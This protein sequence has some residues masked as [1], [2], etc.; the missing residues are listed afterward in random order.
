[1]QIIENRLPWNSHLET[2]SDDDM[3]LIVVHCTEL[4]T[5]SQA[6]QVAEESVEDGSGGC[7][8]GHYYVDKD[9]SVYRYV[10]DRRIAHHTKDHNRNSIGI[11][12]V[13][14]GRYPKWFVSTNQTPVEEYPLVQ[15][16]TVK[17]LI[18][19]LR[20]RFPGIKQLARHSDLDQRMV[21]AEDDPSILIRR[22]IDPGPLFPWNEVL[23]SFLDEQ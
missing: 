20:N 13:N 6:R 15:I 12:I 17:E 22:R 5:L 18:R 1:M 9:G 21:P 19:Y 10:E 23:Q 8:S 2:R 16:E 14:S 11:E 4:P 3:K 7:V